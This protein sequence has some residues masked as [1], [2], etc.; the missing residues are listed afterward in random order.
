MSDFECRMDSTLI[1]CIRVDGASD[2]GPAHHEVQ[3]LAT[4]R[5]LEQGKACTLISSRCSRF[6][7]LNR[8][9]LQKGRL[10]MAH[11][12]VFIPSTIH[13]SNFHRDG[14]ID[15]EQLETNLETAGDVY[16]SRCNGASFQESQIMLFKGS[17]DD[18]AKKLQEMRPH[19]E[20]FLK[21]SRKDKQE[22]KKSNRCCMNILKTFAICENGIW[23]RESQAITCFSCYRA[24]KRTVRIVC[25][26]GKPDKEL[27][28]YEDGPPPLSYIPIP[29]PDVSK[30]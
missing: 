20:T 9:E 8:V 2:E 18:L 25:S 12:N 19:L 16:I 27:C 24:M 6:S 13:E 1:D 30:L 14:G 17:K 5:H 23:L 11:T 4:E 28:W 15:Y 10:A 3:F 29:I 26:T 7:Y 21:G 22:L